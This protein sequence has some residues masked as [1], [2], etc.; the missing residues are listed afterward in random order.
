MDNEHLDKYVRGVIW[1]PLYILGLAIFTSFSM[2]VS[3]V[4]FLLLLIILQG[5]YKVIFVHGFVN[6]K[7]NWL[8]FVIILGLQLTVMSFM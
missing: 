5:I 2:L 3:L 8:K 4:L 1:L 6:E 7:Y